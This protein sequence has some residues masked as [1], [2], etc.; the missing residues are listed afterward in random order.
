M[1]DDTDDLIT[2]LCTR[3]GMIMEDTSVTALT[4]GC[5]D[6]HERLAA[7]TKME[8]AA[9]RIDALVAAVRALLG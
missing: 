6:Q 4:A 7:I 5:L 2:Q 8:M 1:D 9:Q 3:I